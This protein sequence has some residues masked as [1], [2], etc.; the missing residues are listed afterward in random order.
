MAYSPGLN[1]SAEDRRT[2]V[3]F[4]DK[5]DQL[6]L[7]GKSTG[8]TATLD[9]DEYRIYMSAIADFA[10]W[11]AKGNSPSAGVRDVYAVGQQS[12]SQTA[13]HILAQIDAQTE[14]TDQ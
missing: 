9:D 3:G 14:G 10:F 6:R 8:S 13:Q 4:A 12:P 5:A 2:L 11:L 1:L 7:W